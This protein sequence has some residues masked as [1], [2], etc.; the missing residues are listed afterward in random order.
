MGDILVFCTHHQI[1]L[2][3]NMEENDV[4]WA[5]GTYWGERRRQMVFGDNLKKKDG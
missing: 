3:F 1:L 2:G 5:H 4:A